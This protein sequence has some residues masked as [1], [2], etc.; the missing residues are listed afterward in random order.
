MV[1]DNLVTGMKLTSSPT[2]DPICEP[3]LAGKMH[4]TPFVPTGNRAT[5][6]LELIH[7]DLHSVSVQTSSGYKHCNTWIDDYSDFW[8]V[9]LLKAT[10]MTFDAFKVFKAYAES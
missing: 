3:C 2:P 9:Y 5:K 10:S 4:A 8:T 1:R 7:S 6:P